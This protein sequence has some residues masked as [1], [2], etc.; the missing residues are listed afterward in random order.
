VGITNFI[1]S[2][3]YRFAW[4]LAT[5]IMAG[6]LPMEILKMNT[7]NISVGKKPPKEINIPIAV[8]A[9]TSDHL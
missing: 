6:K 5:A 3:L 1:S 4:A 2:V 9:L 7:D 8:P